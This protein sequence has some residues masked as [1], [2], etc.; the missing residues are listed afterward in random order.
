MSITM[1]QASMPAMLHT[2]D[3]LSA[4]LDKAEAHCG[5]KKIEPAVMASTRLVPDMFALARQVQIACDF[6]KGAAARLS[7]QEVPSWPDT[8]TTLAD[9]RAR[10]A[11]TVA[12]A[13]AVPSA[14]IEGSENRDIKL[15]VGGEDRDF[16]GLPYLTH[17]V[18]PNFYFHVAMAYAILRSSG[19]DI[20]KRDF[21]GMA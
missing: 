18:L 7:G 20:G 4:I 15:K 13:K 16:K 8:E 1:Y 17:F 6:V 14:S 10:I 21:L 2:L 5:A 9:L 3:A 19:V 11:K 12:F